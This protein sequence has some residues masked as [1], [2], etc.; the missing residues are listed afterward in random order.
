ML[1]KSLLRATFNNSIAGNPTPLF[2]LL[3]PSQRCNARCNFCY[4]WREK[5]GPELTLDEI[6]RLLGEAW[7][8]GCR[9][10]YLS[11]GEPTIYPDVEEVLCLA[12]RRDFRVSM[13]TNGSRL[14]PLIVKIAPYLDGV[15]VSLDFVG[16]RH[17]ES[18]GVD[19]LFQDAVEG[20]IRAGRLKVATRVNMNLMPGNVE[21][22]EPL[23]DLC[24][25]VGAGLHI[26]LLTRESRELDIEV[27]EPEQ[28]KEAAKRCLALRRRNRDV[29]LTPETY[30]RYIAKGK[31]FRCR[32][33]SLL[34]TVDSSGRVYV[35]C[36]RWEGTKE[37][38]AGNIKRHSLESVW[39]SPAAW[40]IR[41]E[42][43][44]CSPTLDCYTSCILDIS[45]LANLSPGMVAEQVTGNN[46]LLDYFWR[47][48]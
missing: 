4:H 2:L 26:R 47:R 18:R 38:I 3:E 7:K 17:D 29:I 13:T 28:A 11:G 1:F 24:R 32:P 30:F 8:L 15:T 20:L 42:A 37:R 19:G 27:F 45:L 48:R 10:L 46:S 22:I 35:P 14:A 40:A 12:R 43:A 16:K 6:E 31:S 9:F 39:N 25:S 34:L 21:E 44:K 33:L 5:P 36:P 23:M 41:Q